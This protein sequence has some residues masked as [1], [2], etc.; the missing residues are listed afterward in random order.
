MI[1][2]AVV[3]LFSYPNLCVNMFGMTQHGSVVMLYRPCTSPQLV[4]QLRSVVT[5]CTYKHVITPYTPLTPDRVSHRTTY[6]GQGESS[7]PSQRTGWVIAP[8]TTDRVGHRT[9]H[10]GQGESLHPS[11]RTGWVI[12]SLT[13]NR[14][15]H[16][17]PYDE[18]GE[19]SHPSHPT[20]WVIASLTTDRVSHH[21]P[22]TG[23]GVITLFAV[24][25]G[26]LHGAPIRGQLIH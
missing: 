6:T 9:P 10:T 2:V 21:T 25:S 1:K 17:T 15:S 14:V 4:Q 11:H 26:A 16:H 19:S 8:V 12:A 23:Q 22:H 24:Q 18:Q 13:T 7:H 20:R 3:L 5:Q